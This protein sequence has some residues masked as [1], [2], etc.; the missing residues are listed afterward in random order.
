MIKL[1]NIGKKLSLIKQQQLILT[2]EQLMIIKRKL[3]I[4]MINNMNYK[5]WNKYLKI[6]LKL[7]KNYQII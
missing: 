1:K 2:Q 3:I 6:Y 5:K 4:L 7:S